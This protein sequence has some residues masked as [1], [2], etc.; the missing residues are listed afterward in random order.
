MWKRLWN[1][2]INEQ[3]FIWM[4]GFLPYEESTK[5]VQK[6]SLANLNWCNYCTGY[7]LPHKHGQ[8]EYK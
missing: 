6:Y 3:D 7:R 2:D 1:L 4:L 8:D 5:L